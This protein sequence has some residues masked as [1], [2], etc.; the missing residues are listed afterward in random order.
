MAE[1]KQPRVKK[2]SSPAAPQVPVA[3]PPSLATGATSGPNSGYQM[4]VKSLTEEILKRN[5][6]ADR[7]EMKKVVDVEWYKL[8]ED[9]KKVYAKLAG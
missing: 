5:P 8:P 9:Q 7:D 2:S 1:K 6:C 4:F 3:L